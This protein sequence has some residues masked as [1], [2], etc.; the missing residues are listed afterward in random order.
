MSWHCNTG[1]W[2]KKVIT[3]RDIIRMQIACEAMGIDARQSIYNAAYNAFGERGV[4]TNK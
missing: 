2:N 4:N 1:D 3:F